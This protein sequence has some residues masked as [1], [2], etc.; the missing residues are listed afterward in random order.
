MTKGWKKAIWAT[1][2]A[3]AVALIVALILIS[4]AKP[5][6]LQGVIMR[7][8]EDPRRRLPLA[9][10]HVAL[11]DAA[12][13]SVQSDA[14]G[15]F[16]LTLPGRIRRGQPVT[17]R[18][19]RS[20]YL[21]V[22]AAETLAGRPAIIYMVPIVQPTRAEPGIPAVA[23]GNI[24][25][26]Y[27][28]RSTGFVNVG[29]IAKSFEV[30][31]SGT[32]PCDGQGPCSPD[33]RWKAAVET[34]TLDAGEGNR[35]RN[36]RVSCIAGPCPFTRID[37]QTLS[38]DNRGLKVSVRDWSETATF[39]VEAEVFRPMAEDVVR[40]LYPVIFGRTLNFTLPGEA[41]G[42]SI[43]ADLDGAAI[44]FPLG[45][46][47]CLSWADCSVRAN[48]DQTKVYRCELKPGYRFH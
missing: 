31:T 23:I 21:P 39:L 42:P 5:G 34:T 24:R 36:P 7:Q 45:P 10:V 33:G 15:Y 12:T 41:E 11:A 1:G 18:F 29:S 32:L 28:A 17:L 47:L 2:A 6:T 30:A 19:T 44:L 13:V 25:V 46:D 37:S 9:G 20:G 22:E 48:P 26:R 4:R 14:A 38:E 35:F 27:S 43:E 3:L 16:R 8:D 40:R